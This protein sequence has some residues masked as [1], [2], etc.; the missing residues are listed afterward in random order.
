MKQLIVGAFFSLSLI[1]GVQA[2]DQADYTDEQLYKYAL[3]NVV[4]DQMK[5]EIS[6]VVNDMIKNQEG[7]DG[8]R[9]V[10]LSKAKGDEAKLDEL[11]AN[12]LEKQFMQLVEEEKAERITS[13]KTVNQELATKML[14][15]GG[16]VYK[17]LKQALKADEDLKARYE[18]IATKIQLAES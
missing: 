8:K 14:G 6:D 7:I 5:G 16:K 12:D 3:L 10:E 17:S 4:I 15:D 9:Y 11:G 2:Q 1:S 18:A 13:I